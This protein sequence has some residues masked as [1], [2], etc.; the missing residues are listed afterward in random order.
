MPANY[1]LQQ[2]R[3][4]VKDFIN[5]HDIQ[6]AVA[7]YVRNGQRSKTKARRKVLR[8]LK[9]PIAVSIEHRHCGKG[10]NYDQIELSIIVYVSRPRL[11][12]DPRRR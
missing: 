9:S 10:I 8:I 2:N 5:S 12:M 1:W 6:C 11:P 7:V 4:L 3:D